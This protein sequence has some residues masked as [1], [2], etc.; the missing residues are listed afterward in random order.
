LILGR[1]GPERIWK[2]ARTRDVAG[3][4]KKAMRRKFSGGEWMRTVLEGLRG[5]KNI[6]EVCRRGGIAASTYYRRPKAFLEAGRQTWLR[7]PDELI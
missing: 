7:L 5:E 2:T 6:S 1:L 4:M 3:L